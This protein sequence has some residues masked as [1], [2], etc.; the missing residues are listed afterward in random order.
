M[1]KYYFWNSGKMEKIIESHICGFLFLLNERLRFFSSYGI[2][3]FMNLYIENLKWRY[4]TKKFDNTKK[5]TEEQVE[6]LKQSLV[7]SPSSF[8]LQPWKFYIV[9]NMELRKKI[10]D[11]SYGQPQV[12]DASHLFI[13]ASKT[14][15]SSTEVRA[16]ITDV[17][18]KRE[19]TIES[20][21]EYEAMMNGFIAGMNQDISDSWTA[22]QVYIAL[23]FL[24]SAAAEN[25]IDSCPMEGFDAKKVNELLGITNDGYSACVL[26]PVGFRS[27]ED[28]SSKYPKIRFDEGNI[29]KKIS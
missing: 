8:G 27:A 12:V 11:A 10:Q 20:L 29:I 5:L 6:L 19:V 9:E 25:Q 16:Y 2:L 15:F 22:K 3:I 28:E 1:G 13:L 18:G 14:N 26:C 7:L 23:G 4:A 24:L 17:S 21:A